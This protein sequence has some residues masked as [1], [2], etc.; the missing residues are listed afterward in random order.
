M[1]LH[2]VSRRAHT[3]PMTNQAQSNPAPTAPSYTVTIACPCSGTI[4][5]TSDGEYLDAAPCS[6]C[7]KDATTADCILASDAIRLHGA[8][9]EDAPFISPKRAAFVAKMT[10]TEVVWD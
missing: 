9:A 1:R 7:H 10:T 4:L 8:E 2:F 3:L 5:V 6:T